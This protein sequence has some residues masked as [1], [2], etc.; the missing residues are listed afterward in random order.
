[1]TKEYDAAYGMAATLAVDLRKEFPKIDDAEMAN[2]AWR[3]VSER[4]PSATA[5]AFA[6]PILDVRRAM[7]DIGR[8]GLCR[9][10]PFS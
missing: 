9:V 6:D 7:E 4:M 3:A 8:T 2:K 1:M 5:P 10:E